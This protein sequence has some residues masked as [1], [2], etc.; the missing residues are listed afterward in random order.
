[1]KIIGRK[2]E[3]AELARLRDSG[4]SEF[5]MVYGRRRVGKT[6]LVREFFQNEFAFQVTGIA[7]GSRQQQLLNFTASLMRYGLDRPGTPNN[8][9]D[10]FGALIDLLERSKSI[11]KVVFLDELPWMDTAKSDFVKSLEWFWN[12]WASARD[13]IMLVVCGS[14]ASWLVKKI[15]RNHGGLH[16]RLTHRIKITPFN[17]YE[18]RDFLHSRGIEWEEDLIAECYMTLGGI[19]YYLDLL[20]PAL[21]LAQNIDRLFFPRYPCLRQSF[22]TSMP[23]CSSQA[24]TTSR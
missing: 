20:S 13:D 1:M 9:F 12:S 11:R 16:N 14:A 19:P 15:V 24:M 23:L 5:V 21:S 3:M 17:L 10:A 4:R 6:F 22:K 8:W 2:K 18:V 7:R